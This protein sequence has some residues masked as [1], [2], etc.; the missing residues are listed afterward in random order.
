MIDY[1]LHVFRHVAE[2]RSLTKASKTLHL[3]QP[4]VTKH[5][6][7]LEEELRVPLF[8]RS[9]S[10]VVL[11]DAG[12]TFLQYVQA[13]E[14]SR[15]A[16]ME[17]LQAPVGLLTGRLRLGCSMTIAS[18]FLPNVLVGFRRKHPS[19][20]CDV[21]EGNTE[22]IVG[23][24][25]DQR[26]ELGLV[27][28][29]CRRREIQVRP[30]Y[31]DEILWIAAPTDALA[32]MKTVPAKTLLE[33]PIVSRELGSGTRR[34]VEMALRQ[35]GIPLGRMRI[36]QEL[37]STEAIKR[38]VGAGVGIGYASRLSVEQE[39]A[40]GK[41][42]QIRCPQL[43]IKRSFSTLTPQGPDP[44]GIVQAFSTFIAETSKSPL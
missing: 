10:G 27:E 12:R 23:L 26:I 4:A 1:R 34:V 39:I 11:T 40:S 25:L 15:A 6:K 37:P 19:V 7:L 36:E 2:M 38:M 21:V 43:R 28:G 31:E 32:G 29:P 18:Y 13:M 24:L 8:V 14:K 5:I 35:Q 41:L 20:T 3:S 22:T 17:K 16:V 30:F 9:S 42:V 33:R 44:I